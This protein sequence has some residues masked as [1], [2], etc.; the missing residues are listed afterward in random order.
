MTAWTPDGKSPM[1][2][3]IVEPILDAVRAEHHERWPDCPHCAKWADA[4]MAGAQENARLKAE[5]ARL[6]AVAET[7]REEIRR[8]YCVGVRE[9]EGLEA[10]A[11]LALATLTG[12]YPGDPRERDWFPNTHVVHAL[13]EALDQEPA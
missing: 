7:L 12:G 5:V 9:R 3:E 13:A 1:V 10:A 11:S 8:A 6:T 4:D 2:A